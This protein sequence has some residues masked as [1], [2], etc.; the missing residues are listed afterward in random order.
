MSAASLP[1][2]SDQLGTLTPNT[3]DEATLALKAALRAATS[4]DE[5][6]AFR[7]MLGLPEVAK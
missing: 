6:A 7:A 3:P 2:L 4:A 1:H 5:A